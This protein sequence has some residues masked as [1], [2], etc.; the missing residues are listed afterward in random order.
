MANKKELLEKNKK[1][2]DSFIEEAKNPQKFGK[3]M[4]DIKGSF[5]AAEN[6]Y[7]KSGIIPS[8]AKDIIRCN[9]DYII[10]ELKKIKEEFAI[11]KVKR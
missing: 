1:D 4:E 10:E 9:I 5:K 2:L 11:I 3:M 7:I 6:F 8:K